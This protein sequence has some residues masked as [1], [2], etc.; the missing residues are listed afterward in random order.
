MRWQVR[1]DGRKPYQ[2]CTKPVMHKYNAHLHEPLFA[3][4]AM[5]TYPKQ[6]FELV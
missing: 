4:S 6:H 2:L 5:P 1:C 3:G